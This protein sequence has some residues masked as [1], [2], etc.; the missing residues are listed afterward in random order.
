MLER[1]VVV[2]VC[3]YVCMQRWNTELVCAGSGRGDTVVHVSVMT[4]VEA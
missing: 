4:G 3:M 2:C 1:G